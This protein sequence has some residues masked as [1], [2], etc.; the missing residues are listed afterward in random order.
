VEARWS[1]V[2]VSEDLFDFIVIGAGSAGSAV[3]ARLSEVAS[4]RVLVLEAGRRALGDPLASDIQTPSHWAR[5]QHTEA[6]W[7]YTSVPQVALGGRMT[8]EPRGKLPGGSSNLYIMMHVRGHRLDFDYWAYGGCPGW[9]FADV[10]PFFRKLENLAD[11]PTSKSAVSG[12][13]NV[14]EASRHHPNPT[15][16][17]FIEACVELGHRRLNGFNGEEMEGAG[18]HQVNIKDGR[19]H[20][21]YEAYLGPALA[22]PNI[23]LRE[24]CQATQLHFDRA[25][26]CQEVSYVT[27]GAEASVAVKREV[28]LC[29]GAIESPKLLLLSGIGDPGYLSDIKIPLQAALPGVGK[30]FHNHVLVPVICGTRKAIPPPQLNLSECALFYRSSPG[31]PSPDM[32]MAYVHANPA[33]LSQHAVIM[34][35]G[36]VRPF[37]RG[38]IRLRSTDPMA[39]PQINPN[40]L[41]APSDMQR[42]LEGVKLARRLFRTKAF[43]DWFGQEYLPGPTVQT[44][45]ELRSWLR[46]N[47][48]SYHHQ[49]GSC[50]MGLDSLAV[51]DPRLRVHG[52]SG[53][54]V[55]DASIMPAVTTGNC[56]A[57]TVMIGERVVHFIRE[58]HGL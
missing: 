25:G 1:S 30:N 40:Y 28:L 50:R 6:D 15:S 46:K 45:D 16:A 7:Q 55:A 2:E 53:L 22:R 32:Q 13:L 20:S 43:A 35:P 34:L 51:V 57:A 39:P 14:L 31:W 44:E 49:A 54:R 24:S 17:A 36:V 48:D 38:W 41:D 27:A 8:N 4:A 26:R 58:E 52:L 23:E 12:P 18:W 47:A 37:S 10:L 5:V 56:H 11:E 21:M 33:D 3:A 29:A 9:S 19:R 42:L